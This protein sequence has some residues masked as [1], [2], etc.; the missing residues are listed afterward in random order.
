MSHEHIHMPGTPGHTAHPAEFPLTGTAPVHG[1]V[2]AVEP[3]GEDVTL[4]TSDVHLANGHTGEYQTLI[5]G[6]AASIK[7]I[8][9]NHGH[10]EFGGNRI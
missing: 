1:P 2:H 7:R 4:T 6:H 3:A 5:E 8:P 10:H 9:E